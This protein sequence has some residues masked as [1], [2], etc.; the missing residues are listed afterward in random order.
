[1]S[2]AVGSWIGD[3]CGWG[4]FVCT[5]VRIPAIAS[6][7]ALWQH[8]ACV[9]TPARLG[10][11]ALVVVVVVVVVKM[12]R[13]AATLVADMFVETCGRSNKQNRIRPEEK[14]RSRYGRPRRPRCPRRRSNEV[15]LILVSIAAISV[16]GGVEWYSTT[17]QW[18][19]YTIVPSIASPILVLYYCRQGKSM[20]S[21][22]IER[23]TGDS[24]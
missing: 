16:R 5:T 21:N 22:K 14:S 9:P 8:T 12:M 4:W 18:D 17:K 3:V 15:C 19:E 20:R 2:E 7:V 1:M 11:G 6:L 23:L 10:L 24:L 13:I